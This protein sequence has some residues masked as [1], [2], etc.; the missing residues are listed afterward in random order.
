[1]LYTERIRALREDNDLNQT[2]VVFFA[3]T[4]SIKLQNIFVGG[5]NYIL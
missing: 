4:F 2:T 5:C 1:M 3:S